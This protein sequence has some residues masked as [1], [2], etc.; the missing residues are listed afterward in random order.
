MP[1]LVGIVNLA[2]VVKFS[3]ISA[4]S[5]EALPHLKE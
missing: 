5:F 3:R 4:T 2:N 1:H